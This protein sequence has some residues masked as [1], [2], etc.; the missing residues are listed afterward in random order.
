MRKWKT[1]LREHFELEDAIC[2][3]CGGTCMSK[4]GG[5]HGL[6]ATAAGGFESTH[7]EDMIEYRF[8]LCEKC[9]VELFGTFKIPPET[10]YGY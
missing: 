10:E 5:Q 1:I 6:S 3:K 9:L 7:L 4:H 2:N 8:D